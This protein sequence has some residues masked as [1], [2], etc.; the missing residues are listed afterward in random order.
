MPTHV[1]L[2]PHLDDAV[3]SCGGLIARQVADGDFVTVVTVCA[4]NPPA[5]VLSPFAR[6]LHERWGETITD[7]RIEDRMACGRLGASVHHLDIPDAIYRLGPEDEFLYASEE[8]IFGPL[9]PSEMG[10]VEHL[11]TV[12]LEVIPDEASVYSPQAIGGH[13]DHRLVRRAAVHLGRSLSYYYDLPYAARQGQLPADLP[14]VSGKRVK[15]QLSENEI[16]E[17][18][19]AT[20]AYRSQLSTF[21]PSESAIYEELSRFHDEIGG[22]P[23]IV[24]FG[25]NDG[26]S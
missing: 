1:Y 17:W 25:T 10:L 18:T 13:V 16:E 14:L 2:S 22:L 26:T 15:I 24:P 20:A 7:R 6:S 12:L 5:G 19:A 8:A 11:T 4:G 21:W 9:H 23:L 3:F